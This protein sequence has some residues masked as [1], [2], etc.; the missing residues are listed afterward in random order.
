[1]DPYAP[2]PCGSGKKVKFCCQAI[3]PE[4]AKIERLQ[5]NNQ[6][7]MA[8]QLIDKLLKDHPENGWLVTQRALAL[9]NDNAYEEARDSLVPFLRT[10]P[11][12]PLANALLAL[13]VVQSN[14]NF[15]KSKK[16]VH[17]AFLK[18]MA[19]EPQLVAILAGRLVS[20]YLKNDCMMAARQHMAMV[21]RLG[22]D[23]ER[24]ATFRAMIEFDADA[25]IPYPLR[26][27]HP[28]PNYQPQGELEAQ[29]KK[30]QRLYVH[31]CFSEAADLLEQMTGQDA[32]SAELWHMLGLMRAWDGDESRAAVALH[33]GAKLY[34]DFDQAVELETLAQLLEQKLPEN[35][36]PVLIKTFQ[37]E[38][39]SKLLTRLD[40]EDRLIRMKDPAQL[41]GASAGFEVIDRPLPVE[42]ELGQLTLETVPRVIGK[43]MLSDKTDVDSPAMLHVI[44][45]EGEPLDATLKIVLDAS[46]EL[47]SP[48]PASAEAD[49]DEA[50]ADSET[51]MVAFHRCKDLI[52]LIQTPYLPPETPNQIIR[53]LQEKFVFTESRQAWLNH[54]LLALGGK[55][56]LEAIGDDALRV[57]LAA[58]VYVYDAFL[59]HRNAILD[60]QSLFEELQLPQPAMI[61]VTDELDLNSLSVMELSRI[62]V[63]SLA[64]DLFELLMHRSMVLRQSRLGYQVLR[65]YLLNRPQLVEDNFEEVQQ[66]RGF[67]GEICMN[68]FREEEG[69]S[70]IVQAAEASEQS[71]DFQGTLMWKLREVIY[72]SRNPEDPRV[73]ELMLEL[74]NRQGAKLPVLRERLQEIAQMMQIDPPWESS[75]ITADSLSVGSGEWSAGTGNAA[76][77]KKLWLPD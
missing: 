6:P 35:S 26:G 28:L 18:S 34:Q 49:L 55:S 39:L 20:E 12:H 51:G 72:R 27:G 62:P 48:A 5:E 68:S 61:E 73:Q 32:E 2:C 24:Q 77:E 30:A 76:G 74:W 1:M 22:A 8:L 57:P 53:D 7:H 56:P 60:L 10:N 33:H 43:L 16:V 42:S 44:A 41:E 69:I 65:E 45:Q 19:A 38:S 4:M 15:E 63:Q 66:S 54:P 13:S 64:D 14:E 46:G 70:W 11:E 17:R 36:I 9:F 40:N 37:T 50:A 58:A 21:L 75:V 52:A 29:L 23:S 67:L 3:L 71:G 25:E 31:G 47:I 59:D